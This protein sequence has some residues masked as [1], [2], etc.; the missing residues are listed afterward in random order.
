MRFNASD[1]NRSSL[2]TACAPKAHVSV[3]GLLVV[4]LTS[5]RGSRQ[6]RSYWAPRPCRETW[7]CP[8]W[9]FS[10]GSYR[11]RSKSPEEE[12]PNTP[13]SYTQLQTNLQFH[14]VENGF[15]WFSVGK[16]EWRG[17]LIETIMIFTDNEH[18]YC[19]QFYTNLLHEV[20]C[21]VLH[22]LGVHVELLSAHGHLFVPLHAFPE[23]GRMEP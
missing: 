4:R 13:L 5:P 15:A 22:L 14:Q 16:T 21:W 19:F 18:D 3:S 23:Q 2:W 17:T 11:S 20:W 8:R 12:N 6:L 9:C 1:K 10:G 7:R